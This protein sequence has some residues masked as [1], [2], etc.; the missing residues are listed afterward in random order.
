MPRYSYDISTDIGKVRFL[1]PDVPD[2]REGVEERRMI[3]SNDE[4]AYALELNNDNIRRAAADCLDIIASSNALL[5]QY[6]EILDAQ[7]DAATTYKQLKFRVDELREEADKQAEWQVTRAP[8][9]YSRY[10]DTETDV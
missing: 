4:I 5:Y 10:K 1:I 3:L 7:I 8:T 6:I 2:D 9:Y